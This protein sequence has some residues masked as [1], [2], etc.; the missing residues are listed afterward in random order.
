[1][2][3]VS[4]RSQLERERVLGRGKERERRRIKSVSKKSQHYR[5]L[6]SLIRGE[7]NATDTDVT[8]LGK[9]IWKSGHEQLTKVT[10]TSNSPSKFA[11]EFDSST[12]RTH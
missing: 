12:Y 2:K 7:K 5:F 1:M 6:L 9:L 4:S 10:A 3:T 11:W 8:L